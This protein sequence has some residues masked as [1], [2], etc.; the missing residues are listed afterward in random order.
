MRNSL[1]PAINLFEN[2][3]LFNKS[4]STIQEITNVLKQTEIFLNLMDKITCVKIS[5][6][7]PDSKFYMSKNSIYLQ[8]QL[9]KNFFVI[10]YDGFLSEIEKNGNDY[11]TNMKILKSLLSGYFKCN[12]NAVIGYKGFPSLQLEQQL[13]SCEKHKK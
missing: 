8:Y 9:S 4:N 11:D 12:V 6:D 1:Q 10:R 3:E 13:Y 7:F 2:K 5:D